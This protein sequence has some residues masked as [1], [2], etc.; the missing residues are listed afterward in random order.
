MIGWTGCTRVFG[1]ENTDL[2]VY[3]DAAPG[4]DGDP[5]IDLDRDGIKDL[6]DPCIAPDTDL[7]VNSDGDADASKKAMPNGVDPCPFVPALASDADQDLDG[8]GDACDPTPLA[9]DRVRC[10]MAFTDPALDVAMW[11]PRDGSTGWRLYYPR[12][13]S[14]NGAG[15]IVADWPFEGPAVTT[16]HLEGYVYIGTTMSTVRFDAFARAGASSSD[17]DV[18]CSLLGGRTWELV[19]SDGIAAPVAVSTTTGNKLL[20]LD[21]TVMRDAPDGR[22]LRCRARF[23]GGAPAE[24]SSTIALPPGNLALAAEGLVSIRGLTIYERDDAP[25]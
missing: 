11:K 14:L 17:A 15:S 5:R 20:V 1:I 7:L 10:I 2:Q 18:G 19:T 12:S 23:D 13:L 8:I 4:P 16:Y 9:G 24:V 22:T 21:V 25:P 6:E 3:S